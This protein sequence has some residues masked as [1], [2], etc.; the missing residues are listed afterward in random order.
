MPLFVVLCNGPELTPDLIGKIRNP[1]RSRHSPR[2]I[3]DEVIAVPCDLE[4]SVASTQ[5]DV[6]KHNCT[7]NLVDWVAMDLRL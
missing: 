4:Y 6:E 5:R 7:K 3:P 2:C 1:I